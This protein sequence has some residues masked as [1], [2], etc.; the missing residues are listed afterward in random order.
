LS[1]TYIH[2]STAFNAFE[3]GKNFLP[4]RHVKKRISSCKQKL[5]TDIGENK[6]LAFDLFLLPISVFL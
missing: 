3:A 1:L 5:F 4:A 2:A 6:V